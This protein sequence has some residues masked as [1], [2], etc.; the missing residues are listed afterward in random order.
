ME[1]IGRRDFFKMSACAGAILIPGLHLLAAEHHIPYQLG[2]WNKEECIRVPV[3][4]LANDWG[5]VVAL[6]DIAIRDAKTWV[7]ACL[8]RND[9]SI[10]AAAPFSS[11]VAVINGDTIKLSY[12]I[13]WPECADRREWN[14]IVGGLS[15][16]RRLQRG[17]EPS[18]VSGTGP[19][20][21]LSDYDNMALRAP[22]LPT[23]Q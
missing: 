5:H 9:D 13:N 17:F 23:R 21:E 8:L 1:A 18:V 19:H 15:K 10:L 4:A 2:V 6:A 22:R 20:L 12:A 14:R 11:T 7:G 3:R 16:S